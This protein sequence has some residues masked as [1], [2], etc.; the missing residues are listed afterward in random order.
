MVGG[1]GGAGEAEMLL[2]SVLM[3]VQQVKGQRG[4]AIKVLG[5]V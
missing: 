2:W 5:P 4:Q 1:G 3:C